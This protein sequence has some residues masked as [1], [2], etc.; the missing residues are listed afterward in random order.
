MVPLGV[1]R[2]AIHDRLDV[3][4]SARSSAAT[5]APELNL[6]GGRT[7][8]LSFVFK[9]GHSRYT[10]FPGTALALVIEETLD[11][12]GMLLL[13]I[14][15]FDT[16]DF[17]GGAT[18]GFV[19]FTCTEPPVPGIHRI[20]FGHGWINPAPV[21][22]IGHVP[23]DNLVADRCHNVEDFNEKF[24]KLWSEKSD[25]TWSDLCDNIAYALRLVMYAGIR[26]EIHGRAKGELINGKLQITV[27]TT[28]LKAPGTTAVM[29]VWQMMWTVS[30]G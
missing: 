14:Q 27:K 7:W 11:E 23:G 12:N 24:E 10:G 9:Q 17:A 4:A 1:I 29:C 26:L 21:H 8:N 15:W 2:H 30:H 6:G 16:K 5:D 20:N 18:I 28:T 13:S 19:G 22:E 25:A 3:Y